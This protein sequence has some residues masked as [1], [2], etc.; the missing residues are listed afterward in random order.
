MHQVRIPYGAAFRL[1]KLSDMTVN[2]PGA[3]DPVP[4]HQHQCQKSSKPHDIPSETYTQIVTD[5]KFQVL[6]IALASCEPRSAQVYE[7]PHEETELVQEC[8][9]KSN[10]GALLAIASA[11][12]KLSH[13]YQILKVL[14]TFH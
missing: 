3:Y 11:R 10:S 4:M 2:P 8:W 1:H 5:L 14:K 13:I 7:L 12:Y 6:D 9:M